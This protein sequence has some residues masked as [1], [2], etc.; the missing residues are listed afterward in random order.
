[1]LE[2]R[3]GSAGIARRARS[4][5]AEAITARAGGDREEGR[6]HR[7]IPFRLVKALRRVFVG[8]LFVGLVLLMFRPTPHTSSPK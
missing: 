2:G 8:A 6:R 3:G 4:R 1:M 5:A 7:W